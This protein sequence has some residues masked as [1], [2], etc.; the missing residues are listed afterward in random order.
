MNTKTE[1]IPL[2]LIHFNR[3]DK[4]EKVVSK[5]KEIP[6]RKIV[7]FIDGPRNEKDDEL[8]GSIKKIFKTIDRLHDIEYHFQDKN[9]G[10]GANC[11]KAIRYFFNKY[12]K[13]I[14]IEDDIDVDF[15]AL[16]KA[17]NK[18]LDLKYNS[19]C[20]LSPYGDWVSNKPQL[21]KVDVPSIWGWYFYGN[22]EDFD[23]ISNDSFIQK[24]RVLN[25][26]FL[27]PQA[28]YFTLLIN[29]CERKII[30]TWDFQFFYYLWKNDFEMNCS[31]P[32]ISNNIGFDEDGTH[33]KETPNFLLESN[34]EFSSDKYSNFVNKKVHNPSFLN[35]LKL[36]IKSF[37]KGGSYER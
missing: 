7:V 5:L 24:L 2:L 25:R 1:E 33:L 29:I 10:C 26:R 13:G 3:P 36:F 8:I 4:A 11:H 32:N 23:L 15:Y 22:I 17:S 37:R 20:S 18:L 9:L 6:M 21:C 34:G 19:F 16:S 12:N 35:I 31:L 14:V 28:L 27:F 30:D